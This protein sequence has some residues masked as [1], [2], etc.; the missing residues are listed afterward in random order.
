MLGSLTRSANYRKVD[1]ANEA[2]FYGRSKME[3]VFN[4]VGPIKGLYYIAYKIPG[5]Q[6]LS[7]IE[8]FT[9]K[10]AAMEICAQ[11]NAAAY[12]FYKE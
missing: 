12:E 1:G 10:E 2:F 9:S 3:Q 8:E 4:V 5:T 7:A 11:M 6:N